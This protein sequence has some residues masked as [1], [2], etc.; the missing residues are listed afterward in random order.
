M[1]E[2]NE[3]IDE[4]PAEAVEESSTE[5]VDEKGEYITAVI[6]KQLG[7]SKDEA[8]KVASK[9]KADDADLLYEVANAGQVNEA[10]AICEGRIEQVR[11]LHRARELVER[12][13]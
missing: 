8:S 6:A 4:S 1:A 10:K 11:E 3:P 7:V 9:M 2:P 5:T 13:I 12:G